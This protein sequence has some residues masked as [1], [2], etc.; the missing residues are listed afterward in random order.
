[1]TATADNTKVYCRTHSATTKHVE[2]PDR[3]GRTLCGHQIRA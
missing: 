1:M 3:P 2:N